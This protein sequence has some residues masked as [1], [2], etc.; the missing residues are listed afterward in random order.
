[1]KL[2]S[3]TI[4]T[5]IKEARTAQG[6]TQAKLA[7]SC[8]LSVKQISEIERDKSLPRAIPNFALIIQ[9]L[10]I[11]PDVILFGET[12]VTKSAVF[13]RKIFVS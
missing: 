5:R 9:T 13:P 6:I 12:S 10:N 2:K 8:N 4:G 1:M 3:K 7:E 11:D